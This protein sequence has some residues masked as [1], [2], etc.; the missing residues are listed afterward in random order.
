[1]WAP[2]STAFHTTRVSRLYVSLDEAA[3]H[4]SRSLSGARDVTANLPENHLISW[5]YMVL[6]DFL[7]HWLDPSPWR[8]DGPG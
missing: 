2:L 1:M 3:G 5:R 8:V 7:M 4:Y 6:A